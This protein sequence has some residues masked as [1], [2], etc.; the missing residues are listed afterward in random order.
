[1]SQR[2]SLPAAGVLEV[3]N[4]PDGITPAMTRAEL[5]ETVVCK[6]PLLV[7]SALQKYAGFG[8]EMQLTDCGSNL[9]EQAYCIFLSKLTVDRAVGRLGS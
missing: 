2:K 8:N 9:L 5:A 7:A 6:S 3:R 1:M 4:E